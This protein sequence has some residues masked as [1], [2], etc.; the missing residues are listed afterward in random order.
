[1]FH[2]VLLD[3]I[4]VNLFDNAPVPN[5]LSVGLNLCKITRFP[6]KPCIQW[7]G[8]LEYTHHSKGYA[9]E[10]PGTQGWRGLPKR[11]DLQKMW[12]RYFR[13]IWAILGRFYNLVKGFNAC[14]VSFYYV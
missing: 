12:G 1:M 2:I 5:L 9:P 7:D 8:E 3:V 10:E 14:L 4:V 13:H 6:T 11:S